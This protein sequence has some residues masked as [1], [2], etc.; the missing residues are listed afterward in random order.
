MVA[1]NGQ[2]RPSVLKTL[3]LSDEHLFESFAKHVFPNKNRSVAQILRV[4]S[5]PAHVTGA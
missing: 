3:D 2:R 5:L 1:D 4:R